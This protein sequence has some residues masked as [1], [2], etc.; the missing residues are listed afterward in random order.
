MRRRD[1]IILL[2][3]ATVGAAKAFAQQKATPVIGYLHSGVA[4]PT[5]P[6][7]A[8][9]RQGLS[10][11]GYVEG[12]NLAIEYRWAEGHYD[13]L[14]ALAVDLVGRKVDVIVAIGDDV[15]ALAAKRATS[16]I[17][18]VFIVGTDPAEDGLVAS[19][20]RPGG[21]LTGVSLMRVELIAKRLELLA[22]LVPQ[23]EWIEAAKMLESPLFE[24]MAREAYLRW[25]TL[26]DALEER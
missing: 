20:A 5:A 6:L 23:K 19:I 12:Q 8:A 26:V 11:T 21:N 16:T 9:F 7:L 18:L 24:P 10:E 3:G 14:S 22:E 1:L 4:G 2:G 15:S 17:P 25:R 13:R